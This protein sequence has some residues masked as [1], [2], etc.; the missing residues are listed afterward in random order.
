MKKQ[1]LILKRNKLKDLVF[2]IFFLVFVSLGYLTLEKNL[3]MGWF[4]ILFFG[5]GALLFFIQLMTNICY[6]KL[7][8][9][10][11]EERSLFKTKS[12][13]WN[14]VSKFEIRSFRWNKSIH[15]NHKDHFG[16][17]VWKSITA[18]YSIDC[19]ELINLMDNYKNKN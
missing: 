15:F 4:G 3:L 6:L 7:D 11:F 16:K 13:K 12:F 19:K 5:I 14:E 1:E 9:E 17:N 10:G 2:L 8:E 18:S